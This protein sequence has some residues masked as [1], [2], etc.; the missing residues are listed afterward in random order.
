MS[1]FLSSE[2]QKGAESFWMPYLSAIPNRIMTSMMFDE[3]DLQILQGTNLQLGTISRR[4]FLYSEYERIVEILPESERK[5]F[6]W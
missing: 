5:G 1:L 3:Q 2:W 4:N 6:T